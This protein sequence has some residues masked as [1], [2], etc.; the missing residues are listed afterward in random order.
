VA[1]L[2]YRFFSHLLKKTQ[3]HEQFDGRELDIDKLRRFDI[4]E[5]Y[6]KRIH[7]ISITT[8]QYKGIDYFELT[9]KKTDSS[10]PPFLYLHGGAYISGPA[11][12]QLE[13][14]ARLVK[15][16]GASV[17]IPLYPRAPESKFAHALEAL[18]EFVG[19]FSDSYRVMGDSAGGGLALA[20]AQHLRDAGKKL[21]LELFLLS[22]WLEHRF[23]NPL[24]KEIRKTEIM[25]DVPGL[26]Q[27]GEI[28]EAPESLV[29]L[30][31][32]GLCP[33][34]CYIGTSDILYP[35]SLNLKHKAEQAG[36][37]NEYQALEGYHHNW[38]LFPG[39]ESRDFVLKIARRIKEDAL[40]G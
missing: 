18:G 10:I 36:I 26:Q 28:Y 37:L 35:A 16:T 25:L 30:G 31:L 34:S 38:M 6:K 33:L 8:K 5:G 7:G 14:A 2:S 29:D 27:A 20:L 17:Y 32:E 19:I 9:G 12:L 3:F 39:P 15:K 23:E 4:R 40:A 21:P 1:S 13:F 11:F 24:V 22:P